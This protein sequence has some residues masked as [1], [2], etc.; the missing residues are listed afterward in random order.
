MVNG[1]QQAICPAQGRFL[2][3]SDSWSIIGFCLAALL[4]LSPYHSMGLV[5]TLRKKKAQTFYYMHFWSP[6]SSSTEEICRCWPDV[7]LSYGRRTPS[8]SVLRFMLGKI[9]EWMHYFPSFFPFIHSIIIN[10]TATISETMIAK[11]NSIISD[12]LNSQYN[13]G[14]SEMRQLLQ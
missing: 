10:L 14:F 9:I 8:P 5:N 2:L 4:G 3:Q 7:A 1:P 12:N 13:K 6:R 11:I